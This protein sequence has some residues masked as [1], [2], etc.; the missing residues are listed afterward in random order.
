MYNFK[1]Y[2]ENNAEVLALSVDSHFSHL[3]WRKTTRENGG[4]GKIDIPLIADIT[5]SISKSY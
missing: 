4:L 1:I 5:K 2:I 3:A